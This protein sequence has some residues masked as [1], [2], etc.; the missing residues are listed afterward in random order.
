MFID[1]V[2]IHTTTSLHE[3]TKKTV[4]KFVTFLSIYGYG[5]GA[6]CCTECISA[7]LSENREIGVEDNGK[8][9]CLRQMR[10]KLQTSLCFVELVKQLTETFYLETKINTPN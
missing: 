10:T 8:A 3:R 1:G 6:G 5:D 2:N 9:I 7:T 4:N